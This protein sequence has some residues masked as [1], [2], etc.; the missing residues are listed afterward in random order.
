MRFNRS[1]SLS[2][3]YA[4]SLKYYKG[5]VDNKL[6][7]ARVDVKSAKIT[8]KNNFE[9]NRST[10]TWEQTGRS[11]KLVIE[12]RTDPISYPRQDAIKIHKYPITF[13]F[14]NIYQGASTAFRWREGGLK[15][16]VFKSPG[17]T[18]QQIA[19]INIKNGTQLQF[20]FELEFVLKMNNLLWGVCRANRPPKKTNPKDL[21]FFGKHALFC[22]NQIILPLL[23]SDKL[24]QGVVKNEWKK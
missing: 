12:V 6:W 2:L 22:V 17:K 4:Q 5:K 23:S 16:P 24:K 13:E 18:S 19:E 1:L 9:Y 21:V 11:S 14:E 10:K 15:R 20:F 3:I 7:R 8:M